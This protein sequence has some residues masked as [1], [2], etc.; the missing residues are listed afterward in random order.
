M[1]DNL[2]A[3]TFCYASS[4]GIQD[5]K[6]FDNPLFEHKTIPEDDA[7]SNDNE[8]RTTEILYYRLIV[9][10]PSKYLTRK[11]GYMRGAAVA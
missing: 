1:P 3:K 7:T 11:T 4:T 8:E 2:Q 6:G 10:L 9:K 5:A